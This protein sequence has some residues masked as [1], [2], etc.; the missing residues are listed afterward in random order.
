MLMYIFDKEHLLIIEFLFPVVE[1]FLVLLVALAYLF[2]LVASYLEV[3]YLVV[4]PYLEV[5][6]FLCLASCLV[7]VAYLVLL[8]ASYLVEDHPYLVAS[9]VAYLYPLEEAQSLVVEDLFP[10]E[11]SSLVELA[12]VVHVLEVALH[13]YLDHLHPSLGLSDPQVQQKL[14]PQ[15][16]LCLKEYHDLVQPSLP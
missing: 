12:L 10:W 11:D 5:V 8:V 15:Q 9:L 14:E 2:L 3:A 13:P 1:A 6:A 16:Y 7:E 4:H